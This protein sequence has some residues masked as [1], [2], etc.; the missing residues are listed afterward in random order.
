VTQLTTPTNGAAD[1]PRVDLLS[2]PP[3]KPKVFGL[4]DLLDQ[5]R[6]DAEARYDAKK[7][8][9]VRGPITDLP[10]LDLIIG[11][12]FEPGVC[13][14]HGQPGT[15]KTALALQIATK[16]RC[17]ALFV[18]VEVSPLELLRRLTAAVSQE[19]LGRILSGSLSP[20]QV[21]KLAEQAVRAAPRLAIMDA[22]TVL[23][24]PSWIRDV[25]LEIRG[26]AAHVL[27]VV[28]SVHAWADTWGDGTEYETLNAALAALRQIAADLACPILGIAERNRA[29]MDK[30]GLAAGAGTRKI[31]YGATLV[32]DLGPDNENQGGAGEVGVTLTVA[33]N[34]NGM[35]GRT[36]KL[37]FDGA[38]Q[39]FQEA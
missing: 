14:L 7:A 19:N 23:A 39:R 31:E 6:A 20:E 37:R 8:G 13:I 34:R 26:D 29:S 3:S 35:A 5:L 27:I 33:K 12:A 30:G 36:V 1:L 21:L 11:G 28:D 22:T 4:A 18:S 17:P 38:H 32:L 24:D 25:A 15:G 2:P 16:C 9:R 10:S